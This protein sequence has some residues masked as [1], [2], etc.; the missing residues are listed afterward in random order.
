MGLSSMEFILNGLTEAGMDPDMPAAV[1]EKGTSA[2]QRRSD[3][4]GNYSERRI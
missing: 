3:S 4:N 1:L 2:G